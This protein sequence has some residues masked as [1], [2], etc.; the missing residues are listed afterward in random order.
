M[1][2][3]RTRGLQ[4]ML[5]I[6]QLALAA[7]VL[8]VVMM[9][10]GVEKLHFTH[11]P[12]YAL[13]VMAGLLLEAMNRERARVRMNLWQHNF[14]D[15]HRVTLRQ[16]MYAAGGL[17]AYLVVT[18]DQFISRWFLLLYFS[19]LY[20]TLLAGNYYLPRILARRMFRGVR[21]ERTLLIGPAA[22]AARMKRWLGMKEMFGFKTVG[23]LCSDVTQSAEVH[24]F[25]HLGRMEE[26]EDVIH[27]EAITQVVLL[28]L[29]KELLAHRKLVATVEKLGLRFLILSNLEEMLEHP[30]VHMQD[31]GLSFITLRTEPLENP[32]NRVAKR[33]LDG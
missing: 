22:Q 32:L 4:N 15:Q 8:C 16:I 13:V 1:I 28:E 7:V 24:G 12:I 31:D 29:P 6:C 25:R 3:Q 2:W 19:G 26:F 5:L 11:Y 27:R 18:K 33:A 9:L 20:L 10:M 23:I 21:A 17:L 14:L 30:V